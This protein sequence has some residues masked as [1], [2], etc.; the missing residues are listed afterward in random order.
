MRSRVPLFAILL[1]AGSLALPV[2]AQAAIPFFGPIIPQAANQAVCPASWGLLV[3]VINNLIS[4]LITMAIVFI[5]P[6]MI[7][8]SGFLFVVNPV[9][10]SGI[11]KAKDILKNTVVGIVV[12]LAGWMIVDA[13]MV[14]L[15]NPSAESGVT[16]LGAWSSLITSGGVP[17]CLPQLGALPGAGLKQAATTEVSATGALGAPPSG[18]LGTACDPAAIR[19]AV[20]SLSPV[21]ANIFAC[22]AKP[23][24]SCGAVNLNYKWGKGSSA[25][26]PFQVLLSTNSKCY[27]NTACYAAAGISNGSKL[28][29]ASGFSG[30]NP[31]PGS[32]VVDLC[33]KAAANLNCSASAAACLLAQ[34]GGSFSPWQ[35]DK[36]S[37]AQTACINSGGTQFL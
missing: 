22:L 4:L 36:N 16:K 37:G 34:N 17:P 33:T 25:A 19:A 1:A 13:I 27:E 18:K 2:F 10:P 7:A 30:G 15:Y 11:A 5:A 28:N 32:P 29:C 6:L 35:S 23:E 26:G 21:Q 31:I 3:T 9:D 24:S 20:P 12:A 14:V 8:W